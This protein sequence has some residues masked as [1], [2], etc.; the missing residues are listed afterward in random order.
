[1]QPKSFY[2]YTIG[3]Q[4]N[5]SDSDRIARGLAP[6]GYV[7]A[8]AA[9]EADLVIVNTCAVRAKAEQKAFSLLGQLA[10]VK[11][12]RPGMVVAVTGCVAQQEGERIRE[13]APHVD[14]VI[15]TRAV[16]RLG[17]RLQQLPFHPQPLV[18]IEMNGATEGSDIVPA[19]EDAGGTS[20]FVTIMRGCDNY[21]AYCVVP[22]VRG[23]ESSRPPEEIIR[24]IRGMVALGAREVTLLGQNVNSYGVKEGICS[25]AQL[26]DQVNAVEG[27]A[28]I[29][30][31]TSHPKDLT[32]ELINR[33]DRLEKLCPHI[34][35]PVQAG[36]NRILARMNRR[37][38][39]E[40]YLDNITKLRNSC[41]QIAITSD[42]IVGFPGES[43]TDFE[44]TLDLMRQVEFDSVFAFSYSD[45]P[46]TP[47][48]SFPDKVTERE[49]RERLQAVLA[50]QEGITFAKHQAL[51]GS[52]QAILTE[53]FS[54]RPAVDAGGRN[55][56]KQWTGRTPGNKIV[57]FLGTDPRESA[58]LIHPGRVAQVRIQ[59]ALAHSLWGCLERP[60]A[61]GLP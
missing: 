1:M 48:R 37:Y 56:R 21:C 33:F 15:G 57:H 17:A 49:K 30:F 44:A 47:A 45:R 55:S 28:R 11:A 39:R 22:F 53:G 18:D 32:P 25:F 7:P 60:D 58:E 31:T 23:R 43:E 20:R 35:L 8:P 34:H 4:M 9:G 19:G 36:S 46:N 2:I 6:L 38:T 26:L 59:R 41:A 14:L 52:V 13:R 42:I 16:H 29:R 12:R 5:V 61:S 54:R 27:L 50:L 10:A 3:C 40:H 51:V 24:E